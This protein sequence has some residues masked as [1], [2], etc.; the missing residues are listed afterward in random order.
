MKDSSIVKH[1]TVQ[2][3][4]SSLTQKAKRDTMFSLTI[5][6][7]L[8]LTPLE[9]W[10]TLRDITQIASSLQVMKESRQ[11]YMPL[12]M[13]LIHVILQMMLPGYLQV[14]FHQITVVKS[15]GISLTTLSRHPIYR[16]FALQLMSALTSQD[17]ILAVKTSA[18]SLSRME[19]I[20]QKVILTLAMVY[21]LGNQMTLMYSKLVFTTSRSR[22]LLVQWRKLSLSP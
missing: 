5:S 15:S 18:A 2:V 13:F 4:H 6:A 16:T 21:S 20:L 11:K 1:L 17:P 7:T 19:T 3:I 14:H 8:D 12:L 10:L 9:S 22:L